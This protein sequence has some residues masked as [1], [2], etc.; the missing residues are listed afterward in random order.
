MAFLRAKKF[1]MNRSYES[2]EFTIKFMK[3]HPE[4]F[5]NIT[6]DDYEYT[7][8]PDSPIIFMKNRDKEGRAIYIYRG[9]NFKD[10]SHKHLRRNYLTP[11]L[12]I[13][14]V[15][16]Q[17]KGLIIIFDFRDINLKT[18][19]TIPIS[20]IHDFFKVSKYC[21]I[22][23]KQLNFIGM[24]AFF[25]PIFEIGKSFTSAKVLERF[26]LLQN[27]DELAQV[28]DVS[29]LPED[30][31][32]SSSDLAEYETFEAGVAFANLFTKFDVNFNHIQEHENVGSFRKLEID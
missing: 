26:N 31:G 6:K 32:G 14:D 15:E 4:I 12:F 11:H 8:E 23:P 18:F 16:T 1:S 13:Y 5:N 28:M 20:F 21:A 10:F 30:Y 22:K 24:P 19:S 27:V 29:V 2:F 9:K 3:S 25:K 7:R 17:T